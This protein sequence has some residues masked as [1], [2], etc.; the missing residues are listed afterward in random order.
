MSEGVFCMV[1]FGVLGYIFMCLGIA[2]GTIAAVALI[3]HIK[4]KQGKKIENIIMDTYIQP[5]ALKQEDPYA[6]LDRTPSEI[7]EQDIIVPTGET[8]VIQN[9]DGSPI[10]LSEIQSYIEAQPLSDVVAQ[11]R[12]QEDQSYS[13]IKRRL[14]KK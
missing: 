5:A 7:A 13:I 12:K 11:H 1:N 3:K 6:D 2:T 10:S 4:P 14:N 8:N 9:A